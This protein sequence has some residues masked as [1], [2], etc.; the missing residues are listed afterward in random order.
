MNDYMSHWGLREKPFEDLRDPRFFYESSEHRE[1]LDRLLYVV[2]DR[3]MGIGLLTGEIGSGKTITR[4]VLERSL[5]KQEY[6]V[7]A[8]D[9]SG[10]SFNDLLYDMAKR[11]TFQHVAF[12]MSGTKLEDRRNDRYYLLDV[13]R[14]HVYHL[15]EVEHR[16]FVAVIDE[17]QQMDADGLDN[18]KNLTN[19]GTD[20]GNHITVLLVG[21]PELRQTVRDLKPLDQ[22]VSL[23]FHLNNLD[24][25]NTKNYIQHRLRVVGCPREDL[26]SPKAIELLFRET[27]GVPREINRVCKLALDHG[28]SVGAREVDEEMARLILDDLQRH[29]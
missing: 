16:H 21:Q 13:F 28:F 25:T 5:S 15:N 14:N 12:E 19:L 8:L 20:R 9:S 22:R 3:N 29:R 10:L 11:I 7:V 17:A 24:L 26:V 6:E 23:R 18:V 1:A 2:N 4:K 27:G